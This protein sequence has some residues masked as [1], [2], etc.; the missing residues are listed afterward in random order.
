MTAEDHSC[1]YQGPKKGDTNKNDEKHC[2]TN[3]CSSENSAVGRLPPR[4]RRAVSARRPHCPVRLSQQQ[5]KAGAARL[6][7]PRRLEIVSNHVTCWSRVLEETL[8][9][10]C[11]Q[12]G[13]SHQQSGSE[14][15][16]P[17]YT[18]WRGHHASGRFCVLNFKI[19]SAH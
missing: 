4:A 16:S 9:R 6:T 8:G 1:S 3:S 7:A 15:S 14:S 2:A 17:I 11:W 18:P 10:G 5:R 13:C 12:P 19:S